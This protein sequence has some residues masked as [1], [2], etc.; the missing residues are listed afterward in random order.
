MQNFIRFVLLICLFSSFQ[1]PAQEAK[2]YQLF[3]QK[4]KRISY[5]KLIKEIKKSD[6]FFFGE[7]HNNTIAH[8]LQLEVLKA[9]SQ[10]TE[11]PLALGLEMIERDNQ[12][13]LELYLKDSIDQ[14]GLDSTARLWSNYEKDYKPVVDFA[15]ENDIKVVGTNVPRRYASQIYHGGFSVLDSLLPEEKSW[16]A[17]WPIE[18]DSTLDGYIKMREMMPGHGGENLPKAQA[19]KDATMAYFLLQNRVEAELMVH[20]NGT[21]HSDNFEGILWYVNLYKP[22]LKLLTLKT[23]TQNQLENLEEDYLQTANF[24]LVVDDDV[25]DSY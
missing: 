2:T 15:K 13:E 20:L 21:Y 3:N 4:G 25:A 17:P 8:W 23:V 12:D 19:I 9:L 14:K 18:Y 5:K 11:R 1:L 7:L 10:E 22:G 16:M 24:I 6:V